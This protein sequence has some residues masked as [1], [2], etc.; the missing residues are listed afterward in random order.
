M[1]PRYNS[2]IVRYT[3]NM[4]ANG[5]KK[6]RSIE[7]AFYDRI[8]QRTPAGR[9]VDFLRKSQGFQVHMDDF[10][11]E[12]QIVESRNPFYAKTVVKALVDNFD[13]FDEEDSGVGITVLPAN[14]VWL[15]EWLYEKYVALLGVAQPAPTTK[16]VIQYPIAQDVKVKI[17][18]KP[19][20]I[21]A[22]GTTGF[23]TWEAALYLAVYLTSQEFNFIAEKSRVLELGAG[24][25][26]VS[27]ALCLKYPDRLD[28][29]YVTDGD[30][31]LTTQLAR[32][33]QLNEIDTSKV[34]FRR[35]WWN[36]DA[37]PD[38]IDLVVAADVTYDSTVI[39]DLCQCI[40]ECLSYRTCKACL[41]SATV[42]N[43]ET[44]AAFE[45]CLASLG[46]DCR[47]VSDIQSGDDSV[48]D[49]LMSRPLLSAIRIYQ[50]QQR[51]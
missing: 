1:T 11:N 31:Q 19:Y 48:L 9:L 29:V 6:M 44:T 43:E 18:E 35:L 42:R 16:D 30:S 13:I 15:S 25:G 10:V 5:V 32:N 27:A 46:L 40:R 12:L 8:H 49:S 21:S 26:L 2:S 20:L 3:G 50:I 37:I 24:T 36:E 14:D 51:N 47:V 38:D 7:Q 41:V 23:R 22:S 4:N 39:P 28:K 34:D 33:F 45:N 17:E